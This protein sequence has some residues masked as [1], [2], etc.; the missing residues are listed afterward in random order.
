MTDPGFVPG[1]PESPVAIC[2]LASADLLHTLQSSPVAARVSIIGPLETENIGIERM[3]TTL[4]EHARIRWLVVCGDERRGPYQA[5]ALHSLFELGLGD[6][7]TILGAKSRRA[8]LPSLAHELVEAVRRQVALREL[9][10][11][12]DVDAIAR[13]VEEC[14]ANDPGPFEEAVAPPQHPPIVVPQSRFRLKEHDPNGFFV[15]LVD[16]TESRILVEHYQ[17]G[18]TLAHRIVGPDAESLCGA[19]LEWGLVSRLDHAAYLG[20]EL[21]K[22]EIALGRGLDYRQDEPL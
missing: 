11:V 10:G 16:R 5:Q 1:N 14:W 7:G 22:A 13:A 12:H 21:V 19:L 15:I 20:R 9:V 18:G 4:L 8:R 2:T 3:L 6:D 17:E